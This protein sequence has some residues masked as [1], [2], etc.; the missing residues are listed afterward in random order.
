LHLI[1][2]DISYLW[3]SPTKSPS[4]KIPSAGGGHLNSKFNIQ[5][6]TFFVT[7]PLF[8]TTFHQNHPRTTPLFDGIS[9]FLTTFC[10]FLSLFRLRFRADFNP[11][12]AHLEAG[13]W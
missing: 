4:I 10:H 12:S 3:T 8:F 2:F 9:H 11:Q 7:F 6:S 1:F 5:N 13:S